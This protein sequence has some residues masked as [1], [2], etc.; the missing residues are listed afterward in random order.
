MDKLFS[1]RGGTC[2]FRKIW[3]NAEGNKVDKNVTRKDFTARDKSALD[4]VSGEN[5]VNQLIEKTKMIFMT[6]SCASN[7]AK[8][9]GSKHTRFNANF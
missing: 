1:V 3:L 9:D 6:L 7:G 4:N 2:S 5:F 8:E